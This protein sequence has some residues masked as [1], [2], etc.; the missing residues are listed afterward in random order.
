[1]TGTGSDYC[2]KGRKLVVGE[3]RFLLRFLMEEEEGGQLRY[4]EGVTTFLLCSSVALVY[5]NE[6]LRI[7]FLRYYSHSHS[8]KTAGAAWTQAKGCIPRLIV[9][10]I[11]LRAEGWGLQPGSKSWQGFCSIW[12]GGQIMDLLFI[13]WCDVQEQR[14]LLEVLQNVRSS[15]FQNCFP[16]SLK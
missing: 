1:M 8:L 2:K 9:S 3:L 10:W 15:A 4:R 13:S 6:M 12:W 16:L 14:L 5:E 7:S 11:V